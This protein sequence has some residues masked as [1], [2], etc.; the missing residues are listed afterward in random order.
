VQKSDLTEIAA[1][2]SAKGCAVYRKVVG[3]PTFWS[4]SRYG[5]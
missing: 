3:N 1:I 4:K 2:T 5:T